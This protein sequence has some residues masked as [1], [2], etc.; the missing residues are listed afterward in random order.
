MSKIVNLNHL[1]LDL[2]GTGCKPIKELI[3]SI[4]KMLVLTSITL[5]I[6]TNKI[7]NETATELAEQYGM[8]D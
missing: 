5:D 7:D 8:L 4:G 3:P 1:T 6:G 2:K